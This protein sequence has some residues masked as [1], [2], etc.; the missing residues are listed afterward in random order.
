MIGEAL[1]RFF[2]SF[3]N[4][5]IDLLPT[6]D[7]P[8]WLTSASSYLTVVWSYGAG[9]GAW[10]PW[11]I[12]G[13]VVASVLVCVGIGFAIKVARI[14]ASFMTLGGGGAG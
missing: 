7:A 8:S 11:P 9:L 13:T 6:T 5:F 12:V 3:V 10:I 1:I 2:T 14:V 4:F